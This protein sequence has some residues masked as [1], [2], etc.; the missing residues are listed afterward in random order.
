MAIMCA[1]AML[2]WWYHRSLISDA[3]PMRESA[4]L[5]IMTEQSAKPHILT[6]LDNFLAR[7][8]GAGEPHDLTMRSWP[9]K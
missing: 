9:I 7:L 4:V 1:E 5:D 6:P 8:D 2:W 3:L